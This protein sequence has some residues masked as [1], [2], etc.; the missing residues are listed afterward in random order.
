MIQSRGIYI[1]L[2]GG[3][4]N[5]M[6][7]LYAANKLAMHFDQ[8]IYISLAWFKKSHINKRITQRDF[9]LG[10][11]TLG[12]QYEEINLSR[13]NY[14]ILNLVCTR[15]RS[16]SKF[17]NLLRKKKQKK[18]IYLNY[19]FADIKIDHF[20]FKRLFKWNEEEI[21]NE[22]VELR[23]KILNSGSPA[24]FI[25]KDDWVTLSPESVVNERCF[26]QNLERRHEN[27]YFI[28]GQIGKDLLEFEKLKVLS[29]FIDDC[30]K[31]WS[32]YE[33]MYLLSASAYL[34]SSKSTYGRCALYLTK[35]GE[36]KIILPCS[37]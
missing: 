34:Y 18:S 3:L 9:E 31:G 5:Q 1:S 17:E 14:F 28:V 25:R 27:K 24:L 23:K 2:S 32:S 6:M 20:E 15:V 35:K 37:L 22:L 8:V 26:E 10:C 16:K 13:W 7:Q 30:G 12:C 19:H 4:G 36:G 11:F 29:M 21:S 33:K